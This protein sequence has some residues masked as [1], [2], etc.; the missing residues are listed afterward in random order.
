MNKTTIISENKNWGVFKVFFR[1]IPMYYSDNS[2][3][4]VLEGKFK[5][6]SFDGRTDTL[7]YD[8]LCKL[9]QKEM[10]LNLTEQGFK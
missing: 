8:Y 6:S 9:F 7:D 10:I 4:A 2:T 1:G 5:S 3:Y